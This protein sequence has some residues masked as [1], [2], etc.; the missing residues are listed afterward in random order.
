MSWHALESY[1]PAGYSGKALP[2]TGTKISAS[3][4]VLVNGKPAN[5]SGYQVYWYL[6]GDLVGSGP[7][8]QNVIFDALN[9][10][11]IM[12]LRV[13]VPSYPSGGL[14][15]TIYIMGSQPKVVLVAPYPN[16]VFPGFSMHLTAV[17][18]F[19]SIIDPNALVYSWSA[20]GIP[21]NTTEN[22]QSA[23]INIPN[24]TPSGSGIAITVDAK[25]PNQLLDNSAATT[26]QFTHQ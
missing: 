15:K 10:R 18:Y 16:R 13:Q 6:N 5:M 3:L 20:N 1:V 26:I 19:F 12:P 4:E 8:K 9:S 25:N 11:Q 24:N 22:P 23:D 2:G 7:G 17:P 21:A 14:I